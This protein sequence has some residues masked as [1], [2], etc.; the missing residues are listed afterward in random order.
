MSEGEGV[1][2]QSEKRSL[3]VFRE[4]VVV[5]HRYLLI[6]KLGEGAMGEV[7]Q[8][9]DT[10]LG[11]QVAIKIL[12]LQSDAL[13][14]ARFRQEARIMA[15]LQSLHVVRV[16]DFGRHER[17]PFFVMELLQGRDLQAE[18]RYRKRLP[19]PETLGILRAVLGVLVDA[20]AKGLVHRDIK[21]S[22]IFLQHLSDNDPR[23]VRV[24]DF[25][26]AKFLE[27]DEGVS[28]QTGMF[29][30]T[31]IYMAPEQFDGRAEVASDLY[32]LGVVAYTALVGHEPFKGNVYAII[33]QKM[34]NAPPVLPLS[35]VVPGP[36]RDLVHSLLAKDPRARVS[37]A[38]EL[39]GKIDHL[40]AEYSPV[41]IDSIISK[42]TPSFERPFERGVDEVASD[43]L[44]PTALRA[45]VQ[46]FGWSGTFSA[47]SGLF[48]WQNRWYRAFL[49]FALCGCFVLGMLTYSGVKKRSGAEADLLVVNEEEA[50]PVNYEK[51]SSLTHTVESSTSTRLRLREEAE[52]KTP[53]EHPEV[54]TAR[55][56]VEVRSK[57][58][59]ETEARRAEDMVSIPRGRFSMGCSQKLDPQCDTEEQV[60][61]V[62]LSSFS[63]DKTEVTVRA[64]AR[65]VRAGMCS[66]DGLKR[67]QDLCNWSKAGRGRHPINCVD[68]YQAEAYCSWVGKR[69][70]SEAEWER[71]AGGLK[72]RRYPWGSQAPTCERALFSNVDCGDRGTAPVMN[73]PSGASPEGVFD[74]AGNVWEWTAEKQ[75]TGITQRLSTVRGGSWYVEAK[76]LRTTARDHRPKKYRS[77]DIGFRCVRDR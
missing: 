13:D 32:A 71:A 74:M 44:A 66:V 9:K 26:I 33:K 57:R 34:F 10:R 45:S 70:P 58:R 69:L 48:W 50:A 77:A 18:L 7:W 19:W 46:S 6:Q 37:S 11:P 29:L 63:I 42:T 20:H 59:V 17:Q 62:S 36:V 73:A 55:E 30:G 25:G 8:A 56:R 12:K 41:A 65:C 15:N 40:L 68:W 39:R 72:G 3:V 14:E 75:Q 2:P 35:A 49:L 4:G 24:L 54:E 64:Y 5:S 28:T 47:L 21:P 23:V 22:N 60:R 51:R 67:Y 1:H 31:P 43:A 38:S 16:T 52:I 61:R 76:Y 27:E 53:R